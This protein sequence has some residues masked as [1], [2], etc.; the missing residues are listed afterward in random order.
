VRE[1]GRAKEGDDRST[2]GKKTCKRI[3]CVEKEEG[4]GRGGN[5]IIEGKVKRSGGKGGFC[6]L[7][8]FSERKFRK[9]M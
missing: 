4:I 3:E 7:R 1:R 9:E 2:L 5:G 6:A 8:K